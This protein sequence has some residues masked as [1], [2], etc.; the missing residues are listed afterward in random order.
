[1]KA[2]QTATAAIEVG[3]GLAL[4]GLPSATAEL[5]VGATLETPGA[6]TVA[7][8]GGAG[9]LAFGVACWSAR[10]DENSRA[11]AGLG[12]RDDRLQRRGRPGVGVCRTRFGVARPST[13][14]GRRAA[15]GDDRVVRRLFAALIPS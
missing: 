9:L 6:L 10:G 12:R 8:L 1:M 7:R 4:L 3:A 15:F 14:A 13:L 11:C 5:L 2:L